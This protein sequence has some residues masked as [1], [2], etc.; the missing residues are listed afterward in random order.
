MVT[1][2]VFTDQHFIING[3]VYDQCSFRS[4]LFSSVGNTISSFAL[5]TSFN[6]VPGLKY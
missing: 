2:L 5:F 3:I 4:E 1:V 6:L